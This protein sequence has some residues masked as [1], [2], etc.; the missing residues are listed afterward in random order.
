M[1]K[2][3]LDTT[4]AAVVMADRPTTKMNKHTVS[5]LGVRALFCPDDGPI[6]C[7]RRLGAAD[8]RHQGRR[9]RSAFRA[10]RLRNTHVLEPVGYQRRGQQYFYGEVGSGER[11]KGVRQLIHRVAARSP[12]GAPTTV[13]L[14]VRP[15]A[16][17]S[18]ANWPG[19]ACISTPRSFPRLVQRRPVSP[20]RHQ[21]GDVQLALGQNVPARRFSRK[22][23]T[24][25][26]RPRRA[27]SRAW[28]TT[29]KT[30]WS[31][32][33]ARPCSSSSA[34]ARAPIFPRCAR[35]AKSSPA[36]NAF[37]AAFVHARVRPDCRGSQERRQDSSGREDAVDQGLA[38]RRAGVYRVQESRGE[39]SPH[40]GR[41]RLRSARGLRHRPV[42]ERQSFGPAQRRFYAAVEADQ[43]WATHWVTKPEIA[44]PTYPAREM[45]TKMS[46]SAWCCGDPGVQY[47]TTINR[48]HTCPNSGRI[49]AS[50]PVLRSTCSSMI[51]PAT[52]RASI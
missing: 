3:E 14:P 31:L 37:R 9:R 28:P 36:A 40:A 13:T 52:W 48:W 29:W 16:S 23:P 41:A 19:C 20:V 12:I 51:R 46:N 17:D 5:G 34:R 8:G 35:I 43:P 2:P 15:T 39:E 33:A 6:R 38:P 4:G 30:S 50:K 42:P 24:N 21:G 32:P 22:T 45:F 11:E 27:S 44:G 18:T 49:N 1:D 47:D 26:R 25:I 10:E 7:D